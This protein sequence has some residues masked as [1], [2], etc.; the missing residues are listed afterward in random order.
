MGVNGVSTGADN[1]GGMLERLDDDS[2]PLA[3]FGV[4]DGGEIVVEDSAE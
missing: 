4:K 3:Y 2:R 1:E